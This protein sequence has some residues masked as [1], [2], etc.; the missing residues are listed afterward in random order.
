MWRYV[1]ARDVHEAHRRL[2]VIVM[3]KKLLKMSSW[4]SLHA[5]RAP[6]VRI[7]LHL[8]HVASVKLALTRCLCFSGLFALCLETVNSLSSS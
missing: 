1:G 8:V 4:L 5:L 3:P 6:P 7:I 2:S